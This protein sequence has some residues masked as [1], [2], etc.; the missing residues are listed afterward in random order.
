MIKSTL[1]WNI[2]CSG[3]VKNGSRLLLCLVIVLLFLP[4]FSNNLMGQGPPA[5]FETTLD[6]YTGTWSNNGSWESG[7][8]PGVTDLNENVD[9]YGF[10]TRYGDLSFNNGD[11]HVFDT[12]VIYGDLT[13][14]NNADLSLSEGA[15]LIVHGDVYS[16]NQVEVA[17]GGII[18]VTGT[19]TMEGSDKHGSFDND[20]QLY[21]FD[22]GDGLKE[23][24][25]YEDIDCDTCVMGIDDLIDSDIGD[26][27]LGESYTITVSGPTTFC[28]G[29][30][31]TLSTTDTATNYQWYKDGVIISGA[32]SDTYVATSSGEYHVEFDITY[33]GITQSF[34]PSAVTVTVNALPPA[35]TIS[36]AG[37]N[38]ICPGSTL[39]LTSSAGSSY[40]WSTGETTQTIDVNA[41]GNYTVQ[42][43]DANGCL[44]AVSAST[45]VTV[46]DITDPTITAPADV[47]VDADAGS[48]EATGVVLG[49]AITDDNCEVANVTNDAPATF[50]VGLTTVTWTVADNAGNTATAE[51]I[52]TV[53]DNEDPVI[54]GCPADI[55]VTANDDY[56]G[57]TVTWSSPTVT[58]NCSVTLNGTHSSG[59]F[60]AVGTTTV[61]YTAEDVAGNT[62]T[63]SFNVTVLDAAPP[64]INGDTNV[65][66]PFTT[67]YSTTSVADKTYQW[68]VV[69]GTIVGADTDAEVTISW[70]GTVAGTVEVTATSGSG[71]SVSNNENITKHT[72]PVVGDIVSGSQLTRR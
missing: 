18:I 43:T 62:V 29:E 8:S 52:V 55:S 19:W 47:T 72:T 59:D 70:T 2:S 17:S 50:P 26:F 65:C 49:S 44:S 25:G 35:P 4:Q 31:V 71:C 54:A 36:P 60:F 6:N 57:N 46:E 45:T 42:I 10:I 5:V 28:Q 68:S 37:A 15:I 67:T 27:F 34:S 63:C 30:T 13:L 40:L 21:I 61:T 56:C 38:T 51:Q 9:V 32:T 16:G 41:D 48:C 53:E 33:N 22:P 64:E 58:D 23:G 69:G 7:T 14:G 66:T 24:D 3:F 1:T 39:T 11:L 12:L 20:G